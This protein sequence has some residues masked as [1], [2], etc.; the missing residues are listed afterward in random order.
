MDVC[1]RRKLSLGMNPRIE[2]DEGRKESILRRE[3]RYMLYCL[4]SE[5]GMPVDYPITILCEN[6][7]AAIEHDFE[8]ALGRLFSGRIRVTRTGLIN[9]RTLENGFVQR[10]GKPWEKGWIESAFNAMAN[11]AAV[12]PGQKG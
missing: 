11:I 3:L 9:Q 10:G 1:T 7:S 5:Y 12:L 8:M 4:L 6:A 2:N